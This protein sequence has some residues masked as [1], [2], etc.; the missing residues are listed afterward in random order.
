MVSLLEAIYDL[1]GAVKKRRE[2][3]GVRGRACG[4]DRWVDR[5]SEGASGIKRHSR[6]KRINDVIQNDR[7]EERNQVL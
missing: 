4:L 5:K 7:R 3:S 1:F 6:Q 2:R